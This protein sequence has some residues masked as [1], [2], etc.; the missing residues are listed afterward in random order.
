[1]EKSRIKLK[2]YG[3]R[4]WLHLS[5]KFLLV[6]ID[7]SKKVI[8]SIEAPISLRAHT[9]GVLAELQYELASRN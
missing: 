2:V 8:E 7:T 6:M 1:M 4:P 5:N 9:H 3:I